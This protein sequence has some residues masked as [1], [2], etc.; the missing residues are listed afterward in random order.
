MGSD[1]A[2]AC[3]SECSRYERGHRVSAELV[4]DAWESVAEFEE[5][6]VIRVDGQEC[7][8]G[9]PDG[10]T[11]RLWRHTP[12]G[13]VVAVGQTV[14]LHRRLQVARIPTGPDTWTLTSVVVSSPA[15]RRTGA[16]AHSRPAVG[17]SPW[18]A[19]SG[20]RTVEA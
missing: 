10:A 7:E 8:V 14:E 1:V 11:V 13:A 17:R 9:G 5:A 16:S 3:G 19:P 20:R 18:D 12:W 15:G 4:R 6:S 2:A